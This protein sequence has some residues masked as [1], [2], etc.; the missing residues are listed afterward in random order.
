MQASGDPS[1]RG[2]DAVEVKPT[3]GRHLVGIDGLR[4]L[5]AGGVLLAHTRDII[6]PDADLG[7]FSPVLA[8]AAQGLT[9]FFAISGFLLYRPFASALISGRNHPHLGRYALNR[10]LRIYPAYIFVLLIVSLLLGTANAAP[11]TPEIDARV[12]RV[13]FLPNPGLL[14]L[15]ATMLQTFFPISMQTG[16][17]VA[18]SL[19]VEL[20]FYIVMPLAAAGVWMLWRRGS[21]IAALVPAVALLALGILTRLFAYPLYA[22]LTGT[23]ARVAE[24]G[25][26]WTAVLARSFPYHAH[27]FA[28]G[29]MAAVALE[30]LRTRP[31][32]PTYARPTAIVIALAAVAGTR[33]AGPAA[34]TLWAMAFGA[35]LFFVACPSR[36]GS[37]PSSARALDAPPFRYTGLV[38]YSIYLWHAS[39]IWLVIRFGIIVP[40]DSPGAFWAN[41]AIVFGVSLALSSGT[42][43]LIERPALRLKTRA[44]QPDTKPLPTDA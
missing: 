25:A 33:F 23:E 24:W 28:F 16:I 17:G 19:T 30:Y 11:L 37:A 7:P 31:S 40:G 34:D 5:A 13:G 42:Y 2:I 41:V 9:L 26:T 22:G 18:W 8:I 36:T 4:G 6:S 1:E 35:L 32:T 3:W 29:M 39:V 15:N 20:V 21:I 43:F 27:L 14:L 38:S 44:R 10:A 12:D